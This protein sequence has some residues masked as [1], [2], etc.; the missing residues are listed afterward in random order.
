MQKKEDKT[1]KNKKGDEE[2]QEEETEEDEEEEEEEEEEDEEEYANNKKHINTK[3]KKKKKKE[4]GEKEGLLPTEE[5]ITKWVNAE[6]LSPDDEKLPFANEKW[7]PQTGIEIK[8]VTP[9][10]PYLPMSCA[11]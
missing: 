9:P 10:Y 4:D 7:N 6:D 2:T 8:Y 11:C 3:K 5:M 1:K